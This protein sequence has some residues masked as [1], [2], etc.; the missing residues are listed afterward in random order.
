VRE[1]RR[2]RADPSCPK[3]AELLNVPTASARAIRTNDKE[4]GEVVGCGS[5]MWASSDKTLIHTIGFSQLARTPTIPPGD[6]QT[7]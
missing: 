1:N 3:T 7:M 2:G 5:G 6:Q 4:R